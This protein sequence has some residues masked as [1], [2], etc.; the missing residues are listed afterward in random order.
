MQLNVEAT[1]YIIPQKNTSKYF[2]KFLKFDSIKEYSIESSWDDLSDGGYVKLSRKS[3]KITSYDFSEEYVYHPSSIEEFIQ[4]TVKTNE[5][6]EITSKTFFSSTNNAI[7]NRGDIIA[8]IPKYSYFDDKNNLITTTHNVGSNSIKLSPRDETGTSFEIE[9]KNGKSIN[10]SEIEKDTNGPRSQIF[11]GYIT[12]IKSGFDVEIKVQDYMYF[13]QSLRI[14]DKTFLASK[15]NVITKEKGRDSM[16]EH[17]LIDASNLYLDNTN[18][19]KLKP[20]WYDDNIQTFKIENFKFGLTS[21]NENYLIG[22]NNQIDAQVGDIVCQNATLGMVLKELK[23]RYGMKPFFYSNSNWLNILPF[24]YDPNSVSLDDAYGYQTFV[25]K[26]QENIIS[27]NLYYRKAED[28]VAG[29]FVK[30]IYK[31]QKTLGAGGE[32]VKTKTG[33][34]KTKNTPVGVHVGEYGGVTFTFL[35]TREVDKPKNKQEQSE[36]DLKLKAFGEQQLQENIYTG[37][38]GSFTTFGYPYIRHGDIVQIKDDIY[39]ERDGF[40]RVKKV[41]S[42]GGADT[43]LRQEITIDIKYDVKKITNQ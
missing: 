32:V 35:Y 28:I 25:F 16:M 43:G 15:W 33:K 10:Y 1:V 5:T 37:Y 17:L 6:V 14:T 7:L 20:I 41:R 13:F 30:T 3:T 4:S 42:Y 29:A 12:E 18:E 22:Q 19:N 38:Y 21:S 9:Q 11:V 24:K 27:S 23:D 2:E 39:P 40:Y 34:P 8:I 36:L 26:F 31:E